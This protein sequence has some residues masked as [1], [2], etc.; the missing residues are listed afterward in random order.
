MQVRD[1]FG[2]ALRLLGIWFLYQAGYYTVFLAIKLGGQFANS[3]PASQEKIFIGFYL[4]LA[5]IMLLGTE[6]I[7]RLFYGPAR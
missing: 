2:A 4:F 5:M 7:V 3:I 6:K 1:L